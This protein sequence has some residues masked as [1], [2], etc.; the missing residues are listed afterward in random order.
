SMYKAE[1]EEP[2]PKACVLKIIEQHKEI[3]PTWSISLAIAP[4]K[5][6][7][8]IEW[9]LEKLTEIG[10]AEFLPFISH[11]SE[12]RV[13][14][15]DRLTKIAVEAMKQSGRTY[16]PKIDELVSYKELLNASKVF[17]GQKFI[18]HCIEKDKETFHKTY[19]KGENALILIGP[20]GD[21]NNN[22]VEDAIGH[23]F[24]P[25]TLGDVRYRT[26]TAALVAACI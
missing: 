15:T 6:I 22:E 19:K 20:E 1:V 8:R 10:I 23:G 18:L 2:S 17:Q 25:I 12:R 11:H 4:T 14:K 21:F 13:L 5:N 16:L 7:A 24:I 9:L 26:E 3:A